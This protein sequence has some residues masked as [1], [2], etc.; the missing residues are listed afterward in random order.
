MSNRPRLVCLWL[1]S[2]STFKLAR[3]QQGGRT[4]PANKSDP[5]QSLSHKKKHLTDPVYQLA[6]F[7]SSDPPVFRGAWPT[8]VHEEVEVEMGGGGGG[9]EGEEQNWATQSPQVP[10]CTVLL[11]KCLLWIRLAAEWLQLTLYQDELESEHEPFPSGKKHGGKPH[12][13]EHTHTQ[14]CISTKWVS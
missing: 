7:K 8:D 2:S 6:W 14:I 5:L 10:A 3:P 9:K 1:W 13:P 4:N 11:S 12:T